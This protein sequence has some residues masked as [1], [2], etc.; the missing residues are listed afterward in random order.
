MRG[1]AKRSR[2]TEASPP[3]PTPPETSRGCVLL[4]DDSVLTCELFGEYLSRRGFGVVFAHDGEAAV[5]QARESRP[6][7]IVLDLSM[8]RLDGVKTIQRLKEDAQMR[9]VPVI[10]LTGHVAEGRRQEALGAGAAAFLVKP[11][12]PDEVERVIG[13]VLTRAA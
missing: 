4:A 10:V 13:E 2:V 1:M 9:Q 7:V 12:L 6:D 5:A 11:C 8:P 3:P